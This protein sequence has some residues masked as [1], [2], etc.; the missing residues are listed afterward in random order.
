[1]DNTVPRGG[2]PLGSLL[3]HRNMAGCATACRR[4]K[5]CS[6]FALRNLAWNV[7]AGQV[8][9]QMNTGRYLTITA[10]NWTLACAFQP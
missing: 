7:G 3:T 2:A 1:M 8:E 4:T 10:N 5:N 6:S 9:C